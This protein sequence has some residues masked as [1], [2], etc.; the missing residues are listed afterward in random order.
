L[1]VDD[2]VEA[3]DAAETALLAQGIDNVVTCQDSRLVMGLLAEGAPEAVILDLGMPHLQGQDLLPQ[4]VQAFPG[5]P[6]IV[7]TGLGQAEHVVECMRRGAFDY[8]V[9]PVDGERLATTVRRAVEWSALCRENARMRDGV[10]SD[11]LRHPKAF[12]GFDTNSPAMLRV[13]KYAEAIAPSDTSVLITGETGVGKELLARAIHRLSARTGE[14]VVVNVSGLDDTMFADAL[15]GHRKGGFTGA[16]ESRAGLVKKAAGGTLQLDEIGDLS[17]ASQVK[18][19]RLLQERE[20]YPVGSDE[21]HTSSARVVATT[22]RD[23][24][25]SV[26]SG[27]FRKDLFFRLQGHQVH[28]PPLR[29]RLDTDLAALVDRF[30]TASA[31]RLRKRKPTPPPE[32]LPLLRSYDFPGNVRELQ[33]MIDDAVSRHEQGVLSLSSLRAHISGRAAESGAAFLSR[34]PASEKLSF[35]PRLPSLTETTQALIQEALARANGNQALAAQMLGISPQALSQR[36]KRA[37][38]GPNPIKKP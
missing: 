14:Q 20:Y 36:L 4:I 25:D 5:L 24:D 35:P 34:S 30:L 17:A 38:S 11:T 16:V 13:F 27:T 6:V 28:I 2:E 9:K 26:A 32:L 18:L 3:L 23:L 21:V 1:L 22:L 12:E 29:E 10:L 19:L 7:L 33:S 8:L 37:A 31:E 15:F